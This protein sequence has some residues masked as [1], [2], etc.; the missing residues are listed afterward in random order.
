M[1]KAL[2]FLEISG[3]TA[4]IDALD[5]MCKTAD[6][7]LLTWERKLGGRL[8]TLIVEGEVAAVKQSIQ[9]AC[10]SAIKKPVASAVIAN[11]HEET[12]KIIGISAARI[13]KSEDK[14]T[15]KQEKPIEPAKQLKPTKTQ[16]T[17]KMVE[18]TIKI[19]QIKRKTDK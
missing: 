1:S 17:E 8:V 3:T 14:T 7:E 19:R 10:S 18:S 16:E 2:G 4:A 11:P 13:A 5:I 15:D 9:A 6:V 12:L